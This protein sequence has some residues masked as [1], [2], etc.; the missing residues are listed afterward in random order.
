MPVFFA[1]LACVEIHKDVVCLHCCHILPYCH[2]FLLQVFHVGPCLCVFLAIRTVVQQVPVGY[3]LQ[4]MLAVMHFAL[5]SLL[6]VRAVDQ[7]D[8]P[9]PYPVLTHI[10][11]FSLVV[12]VKLLWI[13]CIV[14]MHSVHVAE[15]HSPLLCLSVFNIHCH[16]RH[17]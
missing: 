8:F 15:Q 14:H 6:V 4:L 16:V 12:V 2:F 7:H 13:P 5:L 11:H 1:S 10:A 9:D 17:Y 3:L